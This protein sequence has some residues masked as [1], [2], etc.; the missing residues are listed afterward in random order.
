[1]PNSYCSLESLMG[2]KSYGWMPANSITIRAS[3]SRAENTI[4][5]IRWN[6]QGTKLLTGGKDSILRIY[7]PITNSKDMKPVSEYRGHT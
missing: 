4:N 6:N 1:M 3:Y 2:A 7:D 5:T